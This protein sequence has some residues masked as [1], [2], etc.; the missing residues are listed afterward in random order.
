MSFNTVYLKFGVTLLKNLEKQKLKTE[1]PFEYRLK[2]VHERWPPKRFHEENIWVFVFSKILKFF[3][4]FSGKILKILKI[5]VFATTYAAG[6]AGKYRWTLRKGL[7]KKKKKNRANAINR[8]ETFA[9][10]PAKKSLL[11]KA[12]LSRY[13]W[14]DTCNNI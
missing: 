6:F 4:R 12:Q 9:R 7:L 5:F 8:R 14:V 11:A 2:A 1:K 3:I 10:N 13:L